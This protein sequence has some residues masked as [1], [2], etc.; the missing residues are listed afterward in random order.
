MGGLADVWVDGSTY[1]LSWAGCDVF[2][3][4]YITNKTEA[5]G[6]LELACAWERAAETSSHSGSLPL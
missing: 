2:G 6:L 1:A 5:S 4:N 3:G